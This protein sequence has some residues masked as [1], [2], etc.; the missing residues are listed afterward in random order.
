MRGYTGEQIEWLEHNAYRFTRDE[1]AAA[2]NERYGTSKSGEAMRS[3]G[4]KRKWPY[5]KTH[6]AKGLTKEEFKSHFSEDSMKRRTAHFVKNYANAL[7]AGDIFERNGEMYIVTSNADHVHITE[8]SMQYDRYVFEEAHGVKLGKT[9]LI[10]HVDGDEMNNDID[11]LVRLPM[12]M[13]VTYSRRLA[14]P[15]GRKNPV[16]NRA[17]LTV[18]ELEW[19]LRKQEKE[20]QHGRTDI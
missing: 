13:L 14:S 11:N 5:K 20:I 12:Q 15:V 9:D 19:E 2:F 1:L 16:I 7:K 18:C 6:W 3:L 10:I 4:K 17:C 8:R